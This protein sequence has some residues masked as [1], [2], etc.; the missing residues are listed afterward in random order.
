MLHC[1]WLRAS[2]KMA[3]NIIA[4]HIPGVM[5]S[6]LSWE[7]SDGGLIYLEINRATYFIGECSNYEPS[8]NTSLGEKHPDF[9]GEPSPKATT[10]RML[11]A[12]NHIFF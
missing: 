6:T 3:G 7:A 2:F 1:P 10:K 9:L 5:A 4:Q 11:V 8:K 12:V